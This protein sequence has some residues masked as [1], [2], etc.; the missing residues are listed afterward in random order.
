MEGEDGGWYCSV[1]KGKPLGIP[2]KGLYEVNSNIQT[3]NCN[4]EKRKL[5]VG[6]SSL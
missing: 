5:Y 4:G 1:K 6:L 2:A 3:D